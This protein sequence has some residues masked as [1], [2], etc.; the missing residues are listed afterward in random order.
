MRAACMLAATSHLHLWQNDQALLRASATAV[1]QGWIPWNRYRNKSQHRKLTLE[2]NVLLPKPT[3]F[4][5]HKSSALT[6][7]EL[8]LALG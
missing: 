4:F 6:S 2:K 3:I 8:S 5:D 7:A 1:T